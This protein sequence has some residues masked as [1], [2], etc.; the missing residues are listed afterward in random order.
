[1]VMPHGH[2]APP[3]PRSEFR[4]GCLG[5][6]WRAEVGKFSRAPKSMT[7]IKKIPLPDVTL[8][9]AS[10]PL[11]I[12]SRDAKIQSGDV[13]WGAEPM[14]AK[15]MPY[16]PRDFTLLAEF[17]KLADATDDRILKFARKYGPLGLCQHGAALGHRD[18]FNAR[19]Y[20]PG[21]RGG[22]DESNPVVKLSELARESIAGWRRYSALPFP[23][24]GK[25]SASPINSVRKS[26]PRKKTGH[27]CWMWD[28]EMQGMDLREGFPRARA[29]MVTQGPI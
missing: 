3:R 14:R 20:K 13:V 25:S 9:Y 6:F 5:Q 15:K 1:M 26:R 4:S 10:K 28:R 23:C 7:R 12:L 27:G 29:A 11:H 19:C 2:H 22:P 21:L 8:P 24:Q 17:V 16:Q 18:R